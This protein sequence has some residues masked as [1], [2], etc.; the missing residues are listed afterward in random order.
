VIDALPGR[1]NPQVIR[2]GSSP[3]QFL[4][5]RRIRRLLR[6]VY[7]LVLLYPREND[8]GDTIDELGL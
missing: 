5:L 8:I 2:L 6:E 1:F 4:Q 3:L 7:V